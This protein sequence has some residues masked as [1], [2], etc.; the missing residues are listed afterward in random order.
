MFFFDNNYNGKYETDHIHMVLEENVQIPVDES[1]VD[2]KYGLLVHEYIHYYQHFGTM[3][4]AQFCKM[5]NLL[6]ISTRLF[7]AH[8]KKI[9]IPFGMWEHDQNIKSY[10]EDS[11]K[12]AG[13]ISCAHTIGNIEVCDADIDVAL[14]ERS[15]V[16]IGIYDYE[17]NDAIVA[18]FDFG[19]YSI[20]EYMAHAIQK[21]IDKSVEHNVIPY[22]AVE[23]ICQEK[24][25][26]VLD[27]KKHII[28]MCQCALM[29]DNPGVGFFKVL[30][31]SI[32]NPKLKGTVFY[33]EF[34]S[35]SLVT[36]KKQKQTMLYVAIDMLDEYKKTLEQ[37]CGC[38]L[39]CYNK[40]IDSF[41]HDF[42]NGECGLLQWLYNGDIIDRKQ[43]NDFTNKYGIPFIETP[44]Y[45]YT[46]KP[47]DQKAYNETAALIG[48][49]LWQRRF[50]KLDGD[51]C[52][53]YHVCKK[54][55][56]TD[57][58]KVDEYCGKEQWKKSQKCL[59]TESMK[60]FKFDKVE[61]TA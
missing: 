22:T 19:Y 12:L 51:I 39:Q 23:L 61:I 25:P 36:Y 34:L 21:M 29:F 17:A 27:D 57:D 18:G 46:P 56:F 6:F 37:L 9:Q 8:H 13:S 49:E 55:E 31:Y 26:D 15:A 33:K 14:K 35:T 42:Q 7:I 28:T 59:M 52:P 41:K 24:Y 4:G 30:Q 43:F 50:Q 53:W 16:N 58:T 2:Y 3:Y 48:F 45:I 10:I 5:S 44:E 54:T 60:Y 32:R 47:E 11:K 40:V 20:I 38:K 1:T